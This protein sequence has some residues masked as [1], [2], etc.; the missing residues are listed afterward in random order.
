MEGLWCGAGGIDCASASAD[1]LGTSGPESHEGSNWFELGHGE[2]GLGNAG[3]RTITLVMSVSICGCKLYSL[4]NRHSP[5]RVD[6]PAHAHP[7]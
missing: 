4:C 2:S 1:G 3:Q 6:A 5:F 7:R